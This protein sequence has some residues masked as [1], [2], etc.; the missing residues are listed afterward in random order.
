MGM[1]TRLSPLAWL[2]F[3]AARWYFAMRSELPRDLMAFLQDANQRRGVLRQVAGVYQF[4]HLDL[5]R[6]LAGKSPTRVSVT[7][8][9]N[10]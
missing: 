6:S 8:G 10:P 3:T 1:L 9:A 4:R 5:Q 2:S 7:G